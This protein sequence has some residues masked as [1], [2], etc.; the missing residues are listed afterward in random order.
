MQGGDEFSHLTAMIEEKNAALAKLTA[1][2]EML[3]V[4]YSVLVLSNFLVHQ[5]EAGGSSNYV[6]MYIVD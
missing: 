3:Q 2:L 1:S 5:V 6:R 4:L